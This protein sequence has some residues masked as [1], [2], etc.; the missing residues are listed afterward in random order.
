MRSISYFPSGEFLAS[1]SADSIIR[2]WN[3]KNGNIEKVLEKSN[4]KVTSVACSPDGNFI[5]S[6][7]ENCGILFWNV[8]TGSI[9]KC[10]L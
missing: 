2:I 3:T 9:A 4:H 10:L 5:A 1:A 7:S 8:K 6:G